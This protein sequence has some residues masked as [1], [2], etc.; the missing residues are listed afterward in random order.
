[1][2]KIKWLKKL[3]LILI[4]S[5]FLMAFLLLCLN[6]ILYI[7]E[8][9]YEHKYD[10]SRK[11]SRV[12]GVKLPEFEVVAFEEGKWL[13]HQKMA[14]CQYAEFDTIPTEDFYVTLD[15]LAAVKDCNWSTGEGEMFYYV[16]N[17]RKL[18]VNIL[19]RSKLFY[20]YYGG[21]DMFWK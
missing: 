2:D 17:Q 16:D 5:I 18:K 20:V 14:D 15:S 8:Y 10:N 9:C 13:S 11:L 7:N 12:T 6:V 21:D 1:M 4:S 19:R 3:L